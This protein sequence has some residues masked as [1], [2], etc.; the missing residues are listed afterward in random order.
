MEERER[1]EKPI[2][3]TIRL[4]DQLNMLPPPPTT[5]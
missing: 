4:N 5:A 2:I 3:E 1:E